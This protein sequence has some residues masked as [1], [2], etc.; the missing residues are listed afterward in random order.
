MVPDKPPAAGPSDLMLTVL[1]CPPF[2]QLTRDRV[3]SG[4]HRLRHGAG[5]GRQG[6]GGMGTSPGERK[7]IPG[8]SGQKQ[9]PVHVRAGWGA[10]EV[11]W[12]SHGGIRDLPE[13]AGAGTLTASYF[14]AVS[15]V[16]GSRWPD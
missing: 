3:F 14:W 1:S 8:F 10:L 16:S 6:L 7:G 5:Q 11:T 13:G 4:V 12:K 15:A 9:V 2:A